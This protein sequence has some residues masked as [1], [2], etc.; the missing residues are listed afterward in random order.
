MDFALA[1]IL[2]LAF[3]LPFFLFFLS[4]NLQ[5]GP[6]DPPC[7]DH[8]C[9]LTISLLSSTLPTQE[10]VNLAAFLRPKNFG[11]LGA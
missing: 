3:F 8:R 2:Y 6:T 10:D 1:L 9:N 11:A 7:S 5:L 4:S